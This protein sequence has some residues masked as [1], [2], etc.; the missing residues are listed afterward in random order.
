MSEQPNVDASFGSPLAGEGYVGG[1]DLG[2]TKILAV[3]VGPD[4]REL[5]RSKKSTGRNH[6]PGAVIDRIAKCMQDAAAEAG[7]SVDQ[8]RAIGIGAPG[9]VVPEEGVLTVAVNLGW[10]DVPLKAELEQRLGV[11]VVVDND[12]RVAVLAEHLA[13]AG[14]GVRSLVGVWLGTGI[15]GG[16]VVN[17]ELIT[18][19]NNS[20]GE[21]GHITIKAGG[22]KCACGGRG[23]LE[24]LASRSAIVREIADQ[25]GKGKKTI[26]TSIVEG[27]VDKAT[28]G[29]LADAYRKGD[30]LVVREINRGAKY[31]SM[32]IASIANVLNPEMAVLGGGLVEALGEPFLRRVT[33][34]VRERPMYAATRPLRIVQSELLD[35]AGVI[36]AS[37]IAR[38]LLEAELHPA[39][40]NGPAGVVAS[41]TAEG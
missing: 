39:A 14:R 38:R 15:G 1:V 11:P 40:P 35:D 5:G 19:A 26:L 12:V 2:G 9:P 33:E 34:E 3:V 20:A 17:G 28:S 32:G 22:P 24:S 36:G 13:G 7:I 8:L 31:L 27:E 6:E 29:D 16:V 37:L 30:K 4:G 18:G 41:P 23:H 25:V 10:H 21:L